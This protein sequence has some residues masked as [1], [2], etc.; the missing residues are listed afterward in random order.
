METCQNCGAKVEK[1][2]TM[3]TGEK[4]CCSHCAFHPLGCRC[5]YGEIGVAETMQ[6][7]DDDDEDYDDDEYDFDDEYE[8]EE[9]DEES[10]E[11][12]IW[13]TCGIG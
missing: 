9:D 3:S 7:F 1:C 11:S 5:K 6:Y 10:D 2:G 8:N 13:R 4:I 12:L